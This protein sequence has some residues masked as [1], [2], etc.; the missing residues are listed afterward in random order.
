VNI[1]QP[2]IQGSPCYDQVKQPL[3]TQIDTQGCCTMSQ[4]ACWPNKAG[5]MRYLTW[6]HANTGHFYIHLR[7]LGRVGRAAEPPPRHQKGCGGPCACPT[8]GSGC[9]GSCCPLALH[10]LPAKPTPSSPTAVK[11][12]P[13]KA[14]C[15]ALSQ[16]VLHCVCIITS[17]QHLAAPCTSQSQLFAVHCM[18]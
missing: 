1:I 13:N 12:W 6:K 11:E 15:E 5:M 3:P 8:G 4:L 2:C 18:L 7:Y 16:H 10:T 9:W 14:W 17:Q